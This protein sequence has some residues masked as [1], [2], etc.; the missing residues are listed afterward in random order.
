MS[1]LLTIFGVIISSFI[2][3]WAI[4]KFVISQNSRLDDNLS[5]LLM[6]RI[7]LDSRFKIELNNEIS[8]NKKFPSVYEVFCVVDGCFF[9]FKRNER[10]LNAGWQS[11]D[12]ISEIYFFRWQKKKIE[13]Y[14][15][16]ISK[17]GDNINVMLLQPYGSDKLGEL[18]V[19]EPSVSID[20]NLY[21]DIEADINDMLVNNKSKTGCL[22]YGKPGTGKTRLVKYF[23]Q[24][25]SL[26]IYTIYLSPDYS[27]F[28]I[29]M[30]FGSIPEKCIVLFEDF[31][32]YFN[33]RECTLKNQNVKFT[34]DVIINALDGIYND[35]QQVVF[36]MTANDISKIDDS[37]KLRSSRFKF[38]RE[39]TPP[40]Y[41]T[42]LNILEDKELALKTEGMTV[43][44]IYFVK[45]LKDKYSVDEIIKKANLTV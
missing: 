21:E 43:D 34:F 12:I 2:S 22:L 25:F 20:K 1:N 8:I 26:P 44:K 11:K 33:N 45:S 5:K 28:D 29:L 36:I 31:D 18:Q 42:R 35:Y 32:N 37:I 27:N 17:V 6:K 16:D 15:M 10:L 23:S 30:M 39:I 4:F 40:S 38:V 14:I 41:E 3:I 19:T 13:K 9:F 7:K 24:K